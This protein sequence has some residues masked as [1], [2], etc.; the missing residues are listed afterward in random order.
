MKARILSICLFIALLG[1]SSCNYLD[2]VE[3][4]VYTKDM[5]FDDF[6]YVK[7]MLNSL[8][9]HIPTGY[10]LL[11]NGALRSAACDEAIFIDRLSNVHGF[12]NGS[13]SE[14]NTLD[15][16]WAYFQAIRSIHLFLEE[17]D[18]L[19]FED[20]KHNLD[21]QNNMAQFRY[22][23]Y[24]ARFLRAYFYFEL[25]KRYGDIPLITAPVSVEEVNTLTR[26]PFDQV[27]QFIVD[28]CD[29]I[30]PELPASY[31][32]IPG[33]EYGR[34][35][36]GMVMTLKSKALL[37]AASPL[38]NP[39]NDVA[40]WRKAA[41]AAGEMVKIAET[42][43][44][45]G[46]LGYA[47]SPFSALITWTGAH[48]G[49]PSYG[50]SE[51]IF[52]RMEAAN[53]TFDRQNYPVG[54]TGGGTTGN[55]PS[56]NLV[57]SFEMKETGLPVVAS[58][59]YEPVDLSF[60]PNNPY[61]GRDPRLAAFIAYNNAVWPTRY[62]QPLEIWEGGRSGK[63]TP[64]ATSTGYYLKKYVQGNTEL[65][66]GNPAT[67]FQ[68]SWVIMRYSEVLLNYAEAVVEAYG[69]YNY[70]DDNIPIS[71]R[72]AVNKVRAREGVEMPPFPE[73]L[74]VEQFKLKLRN[75]R[76]VEL[77][78]ED[79]RF[80]DVRRWKI[81]TQNSDIYGVEIKRDGDVFNYTR[82][83][84]EQRPFS[85]KMYLYP[86]PQSE[87]LVNRNLTQNPGWSQ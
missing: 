55:C 12:N 63:P 75:E 46:G 42:P 74:T 81:A 50:N 48:T 72:E 47:L 14:N 24:E 49:T 85:D 44:A 6:T 43:T 18:G 19:T 22:F 84:V 7:Y 28:E 31:G 27:I 8:Y 71:A 30:L 5:V 69:D 13:W 3:S 33:S 86:I 16:Q 77:A 9:G 78:F 64:F 61:E 41:I 80:W 29:A 87:R 10:G 38:F 65:R 60:D 2:Y 67:S 20:R 11:T 53:N 34:A 57:E 59:G 1:S 25:A 17:I 76:R 52:C 66:P 54:I 68:H 70:T 83:L 45:S 39:S 23:P 62:A 37:Y 51:I 56:Q 15:N 32:A 36:K 58:A 35:S 21:Y 4:G 40:K 26:T 79:Q 73:T 82:V